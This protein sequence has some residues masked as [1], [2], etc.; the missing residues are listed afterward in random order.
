MLHELFIGSYCTSKHYEK[1]KVSMLHGVVINSPHLISS[2]FIF[3]RLYFG[4]CYLFICRVD[5]D[6]LTGLCIAHCR[7]PL[8]PF[9]LMK[10][11]IFRFLSS[12]SFYTTTPFKDA[13]NLIKD[14]TLTVHFTYKYYVHSL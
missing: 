8:S 4:T 14:N 7:L 3:C 1:L 5:N 12:Q 11:Y 10:S 13:P 9:K 2:S 6:R